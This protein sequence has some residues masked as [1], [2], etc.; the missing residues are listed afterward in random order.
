M[1]SLLQDVRFGFRMLAKSPG[2]TA[3]AVITLALA[4]YITARRAPKV[5]PAIALRCE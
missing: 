5:D 4:C 3:M 2:F 1:H